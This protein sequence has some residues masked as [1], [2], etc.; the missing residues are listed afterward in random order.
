MTA[1]SP[2]DPPSPPPVPELAELRVATRRK[3]WLLFGSF[4]TVLVLVWAAFV[5]HA[6]YEHRGALRAVRERD[7][8]L[9]AAVQY[10][11]TRILRN[12]EA[13]NGFVADAY[14]KDPSEAAMRQVLTGRA[15]ANDAFTEL[16]LC[17]PDGR[18]LST[19]SAQEA[20]LDSAICDALAAVVSQPRRLGI[21][22]PF[23]SPRGS[24]QVA[25]VTRLRADAPHGLAVAFT[26]SGMLLALME[27]L[28]L[29]DET[30]VTLTAAAGQVLSTWESGRTHGDR[31]VRP[32]SISAHAAA[33][34]P[35][36][37]STR[38]VPPW[39]L[40][41]RVATLERDA[42]ADFRAR[43][44][45]YLALC[46][47]ATAA[48]GTVLLVLLRLQKRSWRLARSLTLARGRL[49]ELN[50]SL[51]AQVHERT[52]QSRRAYQQLET[53][54]HAI[55]HD[56]RGPLAAIRTFA[57]MIEPVVASHGTDKQ[58]HYA[59]RVVQGA[60][61]L[62]DM[63]GHLLRLGR[64]TAIEHRETVDLVPL[65][66]AVLER[67]QELDPGRSVQWTL[68]ARLPVHGD[69]TL[70]RQLLENLL[71]NAWKFTA[72]RSPGRIEIGCEA[73][74]AGWVRV[75]V[76]DNGAGFD[77]AHAH[78]LFEPF[79]RM[80]GRDEFPGTGIGL[81]FVR[82]IVELHGGTIG[83]EATP[84][85]GARFHFTLPAAPTLQG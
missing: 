32:A 8:N 79:R 64:L 76:R 60:E 13:V 34:G 61:Q 26:S 10:Y 38:P 28:E 67:L 1:P 14:R 55:A 17:L 35:W 80:H 27:S 59:Q 53:F 74:D 31:G 69:R 2:P 70:L 83:C 5:E 65:A 11:V 75:F 57:Q 21:A 81:A 73:A 24:Q 40:T 85:A 49:V 36:L 20:S 4:A 50:A 42:L 33:A 52:A 30:V 62:D 51:E 58:R 3:G 15:R 47:T 12:A 19:A 29:R 25:L 22:G 77:T 84:G 6:I 54:T 68:P 41:V 45:N 82:R 23:P 9:A 18:I 48:L 71:G 46:V 37:V 63:V 78:G 7:N 72:Q 43:R 66:R 56:V 44:V 16:G 39:N